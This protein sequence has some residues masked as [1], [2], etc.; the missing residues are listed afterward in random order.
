MLSFRRD[1]EIL[2]VETSLRETPLPTRNGKNAA[3][4]IIQ[5]RNLD[6]TY[7]TPAGEFIALQGVSLDVRPGEFVAVLGKSG[8][9]KTTLINAL[10]GIDHPDSGTITIDGTPIH[11]LG[12]DRLARWRGDNLGVVFQFFQLLGNLTL[13]QNVTL[14]MD[15]CGTVPLGQQEARALDLLEQVGLRDH[16]YKTPGRISGG[17]QQ[18]VAI[19]RALANDPPVI[20]ADEPTGNLDAKTAGEIFGLFRRLVEE[21]R[22]LLVV[23][24]DEEI[25]RLADR[26][27]EIADGRLL[28]PDRAALSAGAG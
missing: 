5:I 6:K 19:A 22:T 1:V 15:L 25:A 13:I 10:A 12:E 18:R 14:P 4:P 2:S 21:G 8:A 11:T 26:T 7:R 17:Q 9:G 24:H 23:T 3:P 20:V 27:V 16:A 28:D